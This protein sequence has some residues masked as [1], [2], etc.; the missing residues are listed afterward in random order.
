MSL[1]WLSRCARHVEVS[2]VA[3]TGAA[4][5]L[6][7]AQQPDGAWA[8][9]PLKNDPRAQAPM[10]LAAHALLALIQAKVR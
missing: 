10:P 6:A 8:P 9:G 4:E 2:P 5:W 1:R 3:A 7:R